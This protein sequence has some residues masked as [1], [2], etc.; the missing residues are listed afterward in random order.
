LRYAALSGDRATIARCAGLQKGHATP[1][2]PPARDGEALECRQRP[3][4]RVM[5]DRP[6]R[7]SRPS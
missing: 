1:L 6:C 4:A 5:L 2:T 3:V 7:L